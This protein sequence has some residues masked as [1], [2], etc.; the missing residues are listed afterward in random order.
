[1]I[2]LVSARGPTRARKAL[3]R[4][5]YAPARAA[6]L[7]P[8]R[9]LRFIDFKS[10]RPL[11]ARPGSCATLR[12]GAS[13]AEA[14]GVE[15]RSSG[16]A[17]GGLPLEERRPAVGTGRR[18]RRVRMRRMP[19]PARAQQVPG[20]TSFLGITLHLKG[21]RPGALRTAEVE[22]VYMARR[23]FGQERH[24]APG[25]AVGKDLDEALH[26]AFSNMPFAGNSNPS[27]GV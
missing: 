25:L 16:A 22:E 26:Q 6:A 8:R 1:M 23:G 10:R 18:T 27:I 24:D 11:H 17:G 7:L 5:L 14:A 4:A 21:L 13:A 19:A 3:R 15:V 9:S 20:G 12:A 2:S